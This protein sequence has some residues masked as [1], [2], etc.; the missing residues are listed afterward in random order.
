LFSMA[1]PF[2]PLDANRWLAHGRTISADSGYAPFTAELLASRS[3][4]A[5]PE[6][7]AGGPIPACREQ[8]SINPPSSTS[9]DRKVSGY[10]NGDVRAGQMEAALDPGSVRDSLSPRRPPNECGIR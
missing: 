4:R 8:P 10:G 3:S 5:S 2:G 6:R 9:S 1:T 7:H